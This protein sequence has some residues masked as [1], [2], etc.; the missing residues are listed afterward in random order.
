[1][2]LANVD[3]SDSLAATVGYWLLTCNFQ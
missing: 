3:F 2:Q 1:M